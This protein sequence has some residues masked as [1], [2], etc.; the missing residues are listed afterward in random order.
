MIVDVSCDKKK[1]GRKRKVKVELNIESKE[2]KHSLITQKESARME[3][4]GIIGYETIVEIFKNII[5]TKNIPNLTIYG[6]SGSGKSYLV[7]W[8]LMSLFKSCIKERVLYLSLNDERGI[9]TMRE[10]IKAFSN[11]QVKNNKD[12]PP[13]KVI[14]FDQAEYLSLDAQNALRRI[15]ELSNHISRFIFITRNTRSII[16]PILS[17]CLQ[18]NLN[19]QSV[20]NRDEV[21]RKYFPNIGKNVIEDICGIYNNFG[22]EITI[23]ENLSKYDVEYDKKIEDDDCKNIVELLMNK[24]TEIIDIVNFIDN[25]MI[26]VNTV[27][28][29]HKVY[30]YLR[31][32]IVDEKI[33]IVSKKF[34]EFEVSG[35]ISGGENIYLLNLFS[36]IFKIIHNL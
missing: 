8:L 5:K 19:V 35:N 1:R 3:K 27:N 13:V 30:D 2:E 22:R 31:D 18:L 10:K 15:I 16:D 4:Y 17:R 12:L 36:Q 23:L 25:K 21:Y 11:I 29:V 33:G 20:N 6:K 26:N 32:K 9:S 14:V 34:L 28:A 24:N 7:N